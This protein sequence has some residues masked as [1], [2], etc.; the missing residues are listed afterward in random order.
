MENPILNPVI[1][2]EERVLMIRAV[3][4]E[5]ETI[6]QI[7]RKEWKCFLKYNQPIEFPRK[8]SS[9]LTFDAVWTFQCLH[10]CN[11]SHEQHLVE[12]G[13]EF[14]KNLRIHLDFREILRTILDKLHKRL[15]LTYLD[16]IYIYSALTS[17]VKEMTNF[18]KTHPKIHWK[19]HDATKTDNLL[20]KL[21][22]EEGK[23]IKE[24]IIL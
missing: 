20:W 14:E 10:E 21:L 22:F 3:Q 4:C 16:Y 23:M 5:M 17:F 7:E 8:V 9:R 19:H 18:R 24:K 13:K 2:P 12:E 11:L 15:P 6:L 1:T